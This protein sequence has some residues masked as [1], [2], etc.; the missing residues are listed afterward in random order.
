MLVSVIVVADMVDI[1]QI[2]LSDTRCVLA[3][4]DNSQHSTSTQ[5]RLSDLGSSHELGI[6][7]PTKHKSSSAVPELDSA[8]RDAI[9]QGRDIPEI[10]PSGV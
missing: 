1:R 10:E 3:S 9:Y 2:F 5:L 8:I 4:Q 7:R 6:H